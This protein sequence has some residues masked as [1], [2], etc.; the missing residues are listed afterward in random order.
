LL[1]GIGDEEIGG[2][3]VCPAILERF[4]AGLSDAPEVFFEQGS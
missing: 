4:E 1:P 3:A 2:P